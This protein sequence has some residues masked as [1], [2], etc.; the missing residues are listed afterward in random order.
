[1]G[2]GNEA[3]VGSGTG[4]LAR[5][6]FGADIGSCCTSRR[7]DGLSGMDRQHRLKG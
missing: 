7:P 4:S 5:E 6:N 3:E 1:M 2:Q